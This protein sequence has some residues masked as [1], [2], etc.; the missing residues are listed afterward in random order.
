[1]ERR[2]E[3]REIKLAKPLVADELRS[4][5][6]DLRIL[7]KSEQTP[8]P[9]VEKLYETFLATSLWY[10]CKTVLADKRALSERDWFAL[11]ETVD[12]VRGQRQLLKA[13]E[14]G[15]P[16]TE[17]PRLRLMAEEVDQAYERLTGHKGGPK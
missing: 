13:A 12:S 2:R 14:P 9:Q 5:R 6:D 15:K 7:I 4:L 3:M 8:I 11:S 16:I 1:M 17:I 10:Q